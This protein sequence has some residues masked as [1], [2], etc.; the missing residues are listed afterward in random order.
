[1]SF[2][3]K[4][5][6][7]DPPK[8]STSA[9]R[10]SSP[11]VG[12][13]IFETDTKYTRLWNGSSWQ[14]IGFA[15][16]YKLGDT[17]PGGGIIFFVDKFDEYYGF[18]YLEFSNSSVQ[19]SSSWATGANQTDYASANYVGLGGGIFNTQSIANQAG[20][21]EASCVALYCQNLVHGGQSDWYLP[22]MGELQ[23]LYSFNSKELYN[24]SFNLTGVYWSSTQG[25][26]ASQAYA[27]DFQNNLPS[28]QNKSSMG[29]TARP[30]RQF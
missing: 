1:M 15:G 29:V 20:N 28:I 21:L 8:S 14:T 22:S 5:T 13:T 30:I 17:G 25:A 10:P 12:Q 19:F 9:T 3:I 11:E 7:V 4:P 26:S 2:S 6:P 24:A 27:F 23:M 16:E 18:T